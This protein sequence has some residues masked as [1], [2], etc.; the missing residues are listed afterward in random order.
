[1]YSDLSQHPGVFLPSVKEPHYFSTDYSGLREVRD[2]AS[3]E[4]LYAAAPP[5]ALLGD[6]SASALHSADAVPA[7]LRSY[8]DAR[9]VVM[10]RNP[11]DLVV[12][13][14]GE[15][16]AN[17]TEDEPDVAKAWALQEQ[18]ARGERLPRRAREPRML[19]Y[20][21]IARIGS[22][23]ER[24]LAQVDASRVLV[25]LLDDLRADPGAVYRQTLAFLG[26]PDDGRTTFPVVNERH[27]WCFRRLAK[28]YRDLVR[29]LGPHREPAR[30]LTRRVGV[31]PSWVMERFNR[32]P[33][34]KRP[35]D[36]KLRRQ[37]CA[38][39]EEEVAKI[40][41]VLGRDLPAWRA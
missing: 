5:G 16:L 25:L 35:L 3:Y 9:F 17:L 30:A 22:Q 33:V 12:A 24:L 10:L 28:L 39:F 40:E 7:I 38:C 34:T 23:L 11:V 31:G 36:P 32:V 26:L 27:G 20:A 1:M 6:A 15:L 21:E 4:A 18:R 2:Q 37:L 8:P 19:Q 14:H 13:L 29:G 41:Q